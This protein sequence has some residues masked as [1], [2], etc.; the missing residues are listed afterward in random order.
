VR[1]VAATNRDLESAIEEGRFREDLYYRINV[2]Q[3]ALPPLRARGPDILP[4]AMHFIKGFAEQ[5]KKNV[6]GLSKEVAEK[7]VNYAWPGN[8]RERS[9]ATRRLRRACS[10][11]NAR[12]S[13]ASWSA[14]RQS[15]DLGD[16]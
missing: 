16:A 13:I 3:V 5:S 11:S 12:R 2:V 6:T 4:L 8:V 10:A 14:T 1:I 15:R 7:L 9:R